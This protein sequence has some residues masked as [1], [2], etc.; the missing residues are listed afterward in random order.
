M[1]DYEV[2]GSGKTY[3]STTDFD[4]KDILSALLESSFTGVCL[5]KAIR[6]SSGKITDLEYV[7]LNPVAAR[8]LKREDL[9]GHTIRNE[10]PGTNPDG[11]FE[12]YVSV[13][14]T[15][16]PVQQEFYYNHDGLANWFYISATKIK[17]DGLLVSF[18]DTTD[19]KRQELESVRMREFRLLAEALPHLVWQTQTT[20]EATYFNQRWFMY[21]GLSYEASK[22]AG[23][24]TILHPDD[25]APTFQAWQLSLQTGIPFEYEHRLRRAADNEYRWFC[26]RAMPLKNEA[27]QVTQWY[28]TSTD[29]HSQKQLEETQ[30]SLLDEVCMQQQRLHTFLMQAPAM[31]CVL[32][33]PDLVFELV[34][35][36]F[37]QL[38][39]NRAILGKPLAEA[40]PEV[41]DQGFVSLLTSVR[42]SGETFTGNEINIRLD[43]RGQGTLEDTFFNF[44]YKPIKNAAGEVESIFVFAYDVT[45]QLAARKVVEEGANRV[46]FILDNIPQIAWTADP[47]GR[48]TYLNKKWFEYIGST[49]IVEAAKQFTL[50]DYLH[51]EDVK[52]SY[53]IWKHSL[54]TG[55]TF[56]IEYRLLRTDGQYR[57]MLGRAFA[58]RNAA[59]DITEWVGSCTDIDDQK[60][61][62]EA[63]AEARSQFQFL[64]ECIPQLV[65]RT[66]ANGY[67]EY[68]NQRWYEYTGLSY[69]DTKNQGWSLALH[70][71]DYERTQKVWQYSLQ[72]GEPYQIE[73]R[74][75]KV[76]GT[77]RWFLGLALPVK[78]EN[79]TIL[80]WF[81]TCT[82]IDELKQVETALQE[83]RERFH[84]ITDFI[85]QIVWTADADGS[86]DYY[87]QRWYQYTGLTSDKTIGWGWQQCI[88]PD[89][90][91]FTLK[92]WRTVLAT[93]DEFR[94]VHRILAATGGYRW[95]HTQALPLKD[96]AG[97]ILKWF[98][99][100]TDIDDEKKFLED[101]A[102]TQEELEEKNKELTK[103]NVD[104]DNFV[105]M[106]SHDLRSP[107]S[108]L[109]GLHR[110]LQKRLQDKLSPSEQEIMGLMS[111]SV[112]KLNRT[113]RDLTEIVK[114]QK[115]K[116]QLLEVVSFTQIMEDVKTDVQSILTESG[117]E[118]LVDF[119]VEQITYTRKHLRSIL[120]NLFSNA[121]KYSSPHR[122]PIVRISTQ[123]VNDEAVLTVAD[124]G[125]GMTSEQL[126]KLFMMFQRMHTHVDGSG[127]GLYMVKR[128]I[129][130]N[131]GQIM[132]E[133]QTDQ[134]TTFTI[135]F[136]LNRLSALSE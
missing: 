22:G 92:T 10:F 43:R 61:T 41:V 40:L 132:V 80:S 73:Y 108:N 12:L 91:A 30:Q 77:Y 71:D 11:I 70:P 101:L 89:D 20:G 109:E 14:R 47:K 106:A 19:R 128:I 69:E 68:F 135:R 112:S 75:R 116:E 97:T 115:E 100:Y 52:K 76:D 15:G 78:D 113:I 26:S 64:A 117:I 83:S 79:G 53:S 42:N 46:R 21:S 127:I 131:G 39:D 86:L 25:Y 126:P 60:V 66:N 38:F 110:V 133:S 27:G 50:M 122:P 32:Q 63:L 99:T 5:F 121:I 120:Y 103:V 57:W 35:P 94:I 55:E 67:H 65:W 7:L 129:E 82:D 23:W 54:L 105:Y 28:G 88:H 16:Q 33:G 29:I 124:N 2:A 136:G 96:E 6:N 44:I 84:F 31:V 119:Q 36:L 45:E 123:L 58:L 37:Q 98:G 85:P 34:N 104:L 81:G 111:Q 107:I 9:I 87:S 90:V 48:N 56:D 1:K 51:P 62:L 74:F 49:P 4:Q 102:I 114:V 93:G 3:Y 59:G 18:I 72:T 17:E 130:N 95:F 24:L 13:I 8:M 134:G 118:V 125:L